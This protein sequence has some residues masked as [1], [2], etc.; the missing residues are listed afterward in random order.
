MWK[1]VTR[2]WK[3]KRVERGRNK[4]SRAQIGEHSAYDERTEQLLV[5]T[6]YDKR[7]ITRKTQKL[8]IHKNDL[9]FEGVEELITLIFS[10][11]TN[12]ICY[13]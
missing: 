1:V 10:L 11:Y 4:C 12:Y 2:V 6:V 7:M 13:I 8:S 9:I 3:G 5:T